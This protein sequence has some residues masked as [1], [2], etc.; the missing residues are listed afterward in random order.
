MQKSDFCSN[1]MQ[2]PSGYED[3]NSQ[4]EAACALVEKLV[5]E[6][7]ELVEKVKLSITHV[8]LVRKL[9][10]ILFMPMKCRIFLFGVAHC[11]KTSFL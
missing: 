7:A 11:W 6:N 9:Y 8:C 5:T 3:L 10:Y 1:L 4:V 2:Q